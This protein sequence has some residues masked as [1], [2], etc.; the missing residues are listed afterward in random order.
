[1][2]RKL[3]VALSDVT[4]KFALALPSQLAAQEQEGEMAITT[5][6]NPVPLINQP[7]VPDATRPGGAG[8][9]LTVNGTGFVSGSVVKWNGSTWATTVVSGAQL[10]AT[11]L[12]TD[13]AKAGTELEEVV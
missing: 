8:F 12:S 10:K 11:I 4:M 2:K 6:E 13:I 1:M 7:L 9:S 3:M 5:T